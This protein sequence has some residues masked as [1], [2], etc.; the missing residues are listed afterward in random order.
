VSVRF[1]EIGTVK[2]ICDQCV[3]TNCY[4]AFPLFLSKF[5]DIWFKIYE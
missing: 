3:Y 4:T 1:I 5:D 2:T